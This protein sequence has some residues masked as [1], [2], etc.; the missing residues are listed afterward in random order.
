MGRGEKNHFLAVMQLVTYLTYTYAHIQTK[1]KPH[2]GTASQALNGYSD[3]EALITVVKMLGRPS[4]SLA[5]PQ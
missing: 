3:G 5:Y 4:L 2:W 1:I